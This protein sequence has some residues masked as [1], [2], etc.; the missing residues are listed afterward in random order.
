ML[1]TSLN[2]AQSSES[3][4][5]YTQRQINSNLARD[6]QRLQDYGA[7][8]S[9]NQHLGTQAQAKSNIAAGA[10]VTPSQRRSAD[11]TVARENSPKQRSASG[12][13]DIKANPSYETC[14]SVSLPVIGEEENA[15]H[16]LPRAE[17]KPNSRTRI[18]CQCAGAEWRLGVGGR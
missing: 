12:D 15:S 6:R 18:A 13:A 8:G 17:Y 10:D 5:R 9:A 3:Q 2:V 1:A 14:V 16:I 4:L 7:S 11:M